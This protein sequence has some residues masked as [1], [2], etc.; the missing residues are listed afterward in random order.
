M[1]LLLNVEQR[2]MSHAHAIL[3]SAQHFFRSRIIAPGEFARQHQK[4]VPA[5]AIAPESHPRRPL[6]DRGAPP[7]VVIK[8]HT[9]LMV[10]SPT[11]RH[12]SMWP[13]PLGWCQNRIIT[14]KPWL[15]PSTNTRHHAI[16]HLQT[17]REFPSVNARYTPLLNTCFSGD[18][19]PSVRF[20][21]SAHTLAAFTT[22]RVRTSCSAPS[23]SSR[24][25]TC[26]TRSS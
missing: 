18:S 7:K 2:I 11:G 17:A 26:Q 12:K 23:I 3:V 10:P 6:C 13:R 20:T 1:A 4:L 22:A 21:S 14:R 16:G 5:L 15:D 25:P 19:T 8:R 9:K 24:S